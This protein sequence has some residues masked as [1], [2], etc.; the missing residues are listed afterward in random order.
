METGK[1]HI[2]AQGRRGGSKSRCRGPEVG[3]LKRQRSRCAWSP[4]TKGEIK[5]AGPGRPQKNLRFILSKEAPVGFNLTR[6]LNS[7]APNISS[8]C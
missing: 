2:R 7:F 3:S 8:V 4:V 6:T 5:S 1:N